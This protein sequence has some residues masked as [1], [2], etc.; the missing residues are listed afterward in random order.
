M[1]GDMFILTLTLPVLGLMWVTRDG[2]PPFPAFPRDPRAGIF[3]L[4]KD[5]DLDEDDDGEEEEEWDDEDEEEEEE[6]LEEEED[7]EPDEED[8]EEIEE[9]EDDEEE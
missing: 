2:N 7:E 9:E 5:E 8:D 4:G 6:W 1:L 3:A